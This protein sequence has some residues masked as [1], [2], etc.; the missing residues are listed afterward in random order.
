MPLFTIVFCLHGE[1]C[2]YLSQYGS[3]LHES[4]VN[5]EYSLGENLNKCVHCKYP[6][7]KKRKKHYFKLLSFFLKIALL[8]TR[9]RVPKQIQNRTSYRTDS[10]DKY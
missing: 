8:L 7:L 10:L 6:I 2:Y 3:C 4:G 9:T 5:F 1:G